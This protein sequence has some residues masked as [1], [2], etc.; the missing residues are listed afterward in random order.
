[1]LNSMIEK[2]ESFC[3][4]PDDVLHESATQYFTATG[5]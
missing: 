3:G 5:G 4:S 1:M 2:A